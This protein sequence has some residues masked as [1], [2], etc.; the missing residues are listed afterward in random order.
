[1]VCVRVRGC[2]RAGAWMLQPV[3]L[4]PARCVPLSAAPLAPAKASSALP[5]GSSLFVLR[6]LLWPWVQSPL[7]WPQGCS[8]PWPPFPAAVPLDG[9]RARPRESPPPARAPARHVRP[10]NLQPLRSRSSR[11]LTDGSR[12][13]PAPW[14]SQQR[15]KVPLVPELLR[16]RW[17][18]SWELRAEAAEPELKGRIV[19]PGLG[20]VQHRGFLTA[21]RNPTPAALGK[22]GASRALVLA[23]S[24]FRGRGGF[25]VCDLHP[26]VRWFRL[27]SPEKRQRAVKAQF[28]PS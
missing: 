12:V 24:R 16:G 15:G 22:D 1:M 8:V 2:S 26:S 7:R 14:C 20:V 6:F 11:L 10:R 5:S 13:P 21:A 9:A 27:C 23:G 3:P 18:S 28:A 4:S 17:E 19:V 25:L